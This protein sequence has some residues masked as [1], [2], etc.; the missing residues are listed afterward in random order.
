MCLFL[1]LFNS[2][3]QQVRSKFLFK[4]ASHINNR[5]T[6]FVPQKQNFKV[7]NLLLAKFYFH[8]IDKS[9]VKRRNKN[10]YY[11]KKRSRGTIRLYKNC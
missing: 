9:K 11:Q 4:T 7:I 5:R 2:N 3:I 6:K 8:I 10:E 1:F